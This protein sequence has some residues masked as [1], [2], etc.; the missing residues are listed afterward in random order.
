MARKWI[1]KE[2]P[3]FMVNGECDFMNVRTKLNWLWITTYKIFQINLFILCVYLNWLK[4]SWPNQKFYQWLQNIQRNSILIL[5][6]ANPSPSMN[7]K[8]IK[9]FNRECQMCSMVLNFLCWNVATTI[10]FGLVPLFCC[11]KK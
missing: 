11:Q 5:L 4:S 9:I 10:S 3:N 6:V 7:L 2:T 8:G 1:A